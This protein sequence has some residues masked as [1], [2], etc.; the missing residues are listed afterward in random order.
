MILTRL[1]LSGSTRNR[2][3]GK[4]RDFYVRT[5]IPEYWIVDRDEEVI[6]QIGGAAAMFADIRA[7]M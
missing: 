4:K 5:G 6:I 7:R 1:L 3:L 2:D